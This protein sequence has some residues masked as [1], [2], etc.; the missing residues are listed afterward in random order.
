[1]NYSNECLPDKCLPVEFEDDTLSEIAH[2]RDRSLQDMSKQ[3]QDTES[4]L[5]EQARE[6]QKE[7]LEEKGQQQQEYEQ[8]L[9]QYEEELSLQIMDR[10]LED[11]DIDEIIQ[12]IARDKI[13]KDLE[14]KLRELEYQPEEVSAQDVEESL[15]RYIEQGDIEVQKGEVK[16]TPKGARKLANRILRRILEN[17]SSTEI[18]PHS[19]EETGYGAERSPSSRRHEPGDEYD[20]IDFER[21]LLNALERNPARKKISLE[22]EDFQVY[23]EI[24]QTKMVAGLIMDE[25]GSMSGEKIDAAIDTALAV[26]ELIRQEPKDLLKV[27]LF[28]NRVREIPYY[29]ILNASFCGGTTDIKAAL[30]AFRKGVSQEKGDKQAYLITDTEPNTEDGRYVG[31]KEAIAGVVQEALYYRQAGITL[32]IVMLDQTPHLRELASILAKKNLGRAFFTLPTKLGELVIED[33]LTSKKKTRVF[34]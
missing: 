25:S 7:R 16:I 15:K 28:S 18:G 20:R 34:K 24:H 9:K 23:E 27:Y 12:E 14:Q 22:A 30:R 2:S 26:A 3:M 10:I 21:T 32:N 19:L 31:F 6:R 11:V 13:R 17:L 1:M 5:A 4:S 8:Q 29:D 33:Y